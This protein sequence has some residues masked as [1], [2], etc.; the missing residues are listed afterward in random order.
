MYLKARTIEILGQ[1]LHYRNRRTITYSKLANMHYFMF[2]Q[3]N[4][5]E[6]YKGKWI[7]THIFL[8]G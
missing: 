5:I 8:T 4:K 2:L 3:Q 7:I 1:Y 6:N